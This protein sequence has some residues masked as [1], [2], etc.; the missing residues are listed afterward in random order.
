MLIRSALDSVS[1][2]FHQEYKLYA[3]YLWFTS[4]LSHGQ[5]APGQLFT[6]VI[7]M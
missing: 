2:G 3:L 1:I 5:A 4:W 6:G 7:A